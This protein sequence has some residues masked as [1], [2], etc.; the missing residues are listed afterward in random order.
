MPSA[1]YGTPDAANGYFADRGSATW[2]EADDDDKLAA[3]VR[4]SQVI[5]ALYEPRFPGRRAIGYEQALSWPRAGAVT[6]NGEAIADD[7]VPL[8]VTYA[9]YEA[10][11]AELAT[12]GSL[13][14]VVTATRQV[15]REKIGSLETEYAVAT[16]A[17]DLV[18]AAR[19][20]LTVLD[21]LLYPFLRPVLPGIL[22][23]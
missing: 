15:R 11:M 6:A 14:P 8:P 5:D 10:A 1:F 21:G 19:P 22:A 2:V 18:A 9:A 16:S 3:L 23:V 17:D 13:T 4:G 20:V 12:P 7:A